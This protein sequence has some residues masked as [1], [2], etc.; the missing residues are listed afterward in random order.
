MPKLSPQAALVRD[1]LYQEAHLTPWQATGVYHIRSLS[2]R[3]SELR[4]A[5]YDITKQ[6][7]TD[8][9][10]QRYVRYAFSPRQKRNKR[11]VLPAV[12]QLRHCTCPQLPDLKTLRRACYSAVQAR[13]I[14]GV[15]AI[16]IS[17]VMSQVIHQVL[18][19]SSEP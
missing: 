14:G 6:H 4:R 1:H 11:P 13:G 3:I 15:D 10:G 12:A 8:A 5:G 17:R 7:R 9:K 2:S 16:V 19:E 18:Q